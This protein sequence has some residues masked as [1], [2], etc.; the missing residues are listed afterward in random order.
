MAYDAMGPAAFFFVTRD[1]ESEASV[2][3]TPVTVPPCSQ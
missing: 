2:L 1:A 3:A